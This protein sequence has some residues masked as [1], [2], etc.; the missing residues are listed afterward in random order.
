MF[1]YLYLSNYLDYLK[2]VKMFPNTTNRGPYAFPYY[3]GS[4][5]NRNDTNL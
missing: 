2:V 1:N 3:I 5:S 4:E